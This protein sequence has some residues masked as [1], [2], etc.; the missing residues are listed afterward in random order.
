MSL[1]RTNVSE[2]PWTIIAGKDMNCVVYNKLNMLKKR[3]IPLWTWLE[4]KVA[5]VNIE[6]E[7]QI[8]LGYQTYF[9]SDSL[10]IR[11]SEL[12]CYVKL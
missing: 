11:H 8:C 2:G 6:E 4:R 9:N 3:E 5:I 1:C 7:K 10:F 12:V